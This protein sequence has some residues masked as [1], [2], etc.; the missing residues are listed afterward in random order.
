MAPEA[1]VLHDAIEG[2]LAGESEEQVRIRAAKAYSK[3]QRISLNAAMK[4]L[5]TG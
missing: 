2:R 4:L 5:V 1:Y 3:F